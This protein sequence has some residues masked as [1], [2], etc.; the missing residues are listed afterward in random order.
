MMLVGS[1]DR[2]LRVKLREV[3]P[4]RAIRRL[5]GTAKLQ[6]LA[7]QRSP[8]PQRRL[9]M[10]QHIPDHSVIQIDKLALEASSRLLDKRCM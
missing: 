1:L 5:V 9:L 10:S 3:R 4:N 2:I 7:G 6:P 8:H